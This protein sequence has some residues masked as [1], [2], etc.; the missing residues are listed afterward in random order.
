MARDPNSFFPL[1]PDLSFPRVLLLFSLLVSSYLYCF[2]WRPR[3]LFPGL[4]LIDQKS[5]FAERNLSN[6]LSS[7]HGRLSKFLIFLV[8]KIYTTC[9]S[10]CFLFPVKPHF[11]REPEDATVESGSPA[12][13]SCSVSGDPRPEVTWHREEEE[14]EGEGDVVGDDGGFGTVVR[15][16]VFL[17]FFSK[18]T[19][20]YTTRCKTTLHTKLDRNM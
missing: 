17:I 4:F 5:R 12:S 15:I 9:E 8:K 13:F 16:K 10:V 19:L 3:R 7:R 11:T 2:W 14:G 6:H 20:I 18:K 1:D